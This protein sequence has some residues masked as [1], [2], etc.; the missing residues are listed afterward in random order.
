MKHIEWSNILIRQ[1][2]GVPYFPLF[3]CLNYFWFYGCSK[4]I[5][6]DQNHSQWISG[7][8]GGAQDLK[9]KSQSST[10]GSDSWS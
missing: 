4:E 7:G 5:T 1:L 3:F 6:K 10:S 8:Y 2:F 9:V